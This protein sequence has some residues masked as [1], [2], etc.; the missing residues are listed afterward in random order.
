[1]V[2][3]GSI[4]QYSYQWHV[5]I[6]KHIRKE[7]TVA[8]EPITA[9]STP[10]E[11]PPETERPGDGVA[12]KPLFQPPAETRSDGMAVAFSEDENPFATEEIG[13][14]PRA[15]A[16]VFGACSIETF[17]NAG[18]LSLTHEDA[19][20]WVNYL[21][22]FNAA[23][24]WRQDSAVKIWLYTEPYDN[25]QDLYGVDAVLAFYHS[26]HG[27]MD[28]NGVFY[29]P[30]G[31]SWNGSGNDCTVAS[32][33]MQFANDYPDRV[34]YIFWSTCLSCRV[35]DGHNPIRTWGAANKGGFRMLFGF[36]TISWDNP[37]YGKNFWEEWNKNKSFSTAWL[38]GSWRIAHDQ[39]PSVVAC[40][41]TAAEA[42]DRLYNERYLYWGHVSNSWYWWRWYYASSA[43]VAREPQR[44]LPK[45]PMIAR[46]RPATV[47]PSTVDRFAQQFGLDIRRGAQIRATR[48]GTLAAATGEQSLTIAPSGSVTAHLAQPNRVN[49]SQL[50]LHQARSIGEDTVRRY[51]LDQDVSLTFDR[52]RL[53]SEGGGTGQGSGRLEG[54]YIT[55]TTIQYRQVING[56]PVIA[57]NA[58]TVRVTVDNDGTVTTVESSLR[59]VDQ[60][61]DRA[62]DTA[63]S[64]PYGSE[65]G[66]TAAPDEPRATDEA[67]YQQ[68]L[69]QEWGKR[70]ASW[71]VRGHA[72][73]GYATVPGST[74]VG[75]VVRGNNTVIVARKAVEVD[76]GNGI[77]KRYWVETPLFG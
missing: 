24:F 52:I 5:L 70:L 22:K 73:L 62:Y 41:A 45:S 60:L 35:L 4:R 33:D 18:G 56:L 19:G 48:S 47:N 54:P 53:E 66:A 31:G 7:R 65:Q 8:S 1:M 32:T 15:A 43:A 10:I 9:S 51:G 39:A 77:Y 2:D 38:D 46:L 34:N 6:Y 68:L 26:G 63:A 40:G 30:L 58:G 16:N 3:M 67:G 21:Q 50:A 37:D 36:E 72:P 69:A 44:V 61:L 75:Y 57:P 25:W 29:A 71:A 59:P 64:P 76:F 12:S 17:C 28:G 42:Q 74:E 11:T 27:G 49:R 23:N 20:G 55:Q 14:A 13:A